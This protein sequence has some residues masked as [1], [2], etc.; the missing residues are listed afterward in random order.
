MSTARATKW[1]PIKTAP[2]GNVQFLVTDFEEGDPWA[3]C[4]EL[5]RGPFMPDGSIFN[6]NSGNYSRPG[7]WTYW[8]P[9]PE[10]PDS[11]PR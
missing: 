2:R 6:Q 1:R 5:V 8:M 9:L 7:S 11:S 4:I 10:P 3:C